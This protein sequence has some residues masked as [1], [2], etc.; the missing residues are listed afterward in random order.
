MLRFSQT[1]NWK[2]VASR[3]LSPGRAQAPRGPGEKGRD[4]CGSARWGAQHVIIAQLG[5]CARAVPAVGFGS[6]QAFHLRWAPPA[7]PPKP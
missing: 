2:V 1:P 5:K 3:N 4:S 7:P 6:C